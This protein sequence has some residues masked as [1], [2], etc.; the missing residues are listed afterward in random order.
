M[1]EEP[2]PE[3]ISRYE[4]RGELGR[5]MMGVVYDAYD[6]SLH[7]AVALKVVRLLFAI[8]EK[9]KESF[10]R[11]F[12]AEARIAARLSHPG[13]VVVHDIGRDPASGIL[14]IAL[15]RLQGRTLAEMTADGA[16]LPWPHALVVTARMAGALAYA[17]AQGVVHRDVKPANVMVLPTGEPKIM[18]FGLAKLEAGHEMTATGQ[19]VGTPLFMAPEQVSGDKVDGRTDLFSLGSVLYT[20]LTGARAFA[21]ESIHQIMQR[22]THQEPRP[23]TGLVRDLPPVLD[24]VLARAMAK[25]PAARYPTGDAFAEDLHDVLAGRAPRH[26]EGWTPPRPATATVVG[27]RVGEAPEVTDLGLEPVEGSRVAPAPAAAPDEPSLSLSLPA[28]PRRRGAPRP[29][30]TLALLIMLGGLA[31]YYFS[32]PWPD[33]FTEVVTLWLV[34]PPL[35]EEVATTLTAHAPP[36]EGVP[37]EEAPPAA[38]APSEGIPEPPSPAELR[39]AGVVSPEAG[40]RLAWTELPDPGP[41]PA[42]LTGE[43]DEEAEAGSEEPSGVA[44]AAGAVP[45]GSPTAAPP[46]PARSG[47]AATTAAAA[48]PA[49]A[50]AAPAKPA[51]ARPAPAKPKASARKTSPAAK[52]ARLTVNMEHHLKRGTVRVWLDNKLVVQESLDAKV[53][54]KILFFPLRKGVVQERLRVTPGRHHLRVQVRW[55]DNVET[56]RITGSFRAGTTR[57]LEVR[58]SRLG[59]KLS[60]EWK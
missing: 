4:I 40:E 25:D 9:E 15:E 41:T 31:A 34:P 36:S 56:K 23:A 32:S 18:D 28:A 13:I 7:R 54:K 53:A 21:G 58:I 48:P 26:L 16:R 19:F 42:I 10:E 20:L 38:T 37:G 50:R 39:A 8:T 24:R 14:Y 27:A 35:P 3:T 44:D 1:A 60:L 43:E 6:P 45:E 33:R 17:H 12:L 49:T 11:R 59:G 2:L 57:R 52:P 22:V 51:P 5:G 30:R 29:L 46:V 47:P 55:G